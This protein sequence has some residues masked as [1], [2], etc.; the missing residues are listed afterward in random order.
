MK[1]KRDV[2]ETRMNTHKIVTNQVGGDLSGREGYTLKKLY[3][4]K[5]GFADIIVDTPKGEIEINVKGSKAGKNYVLLNPLKEP[6]DNQYYA[7]GSLA[8]PNRISYLSHEH[9]KE[10]IDEDIKRCDEKKR[11]GTIYSKKWTSYGFPYDWTHRYND[12]LP[13]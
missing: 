3:S 8:E 9:V 7:F 4:Q 2:Q 5:K 10:L 1:D 6:K 13:K 12:D 11:N